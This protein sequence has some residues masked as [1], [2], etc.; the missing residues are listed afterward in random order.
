MISDHTKS[1]GQ[2][3]KVTTTPPPFPT[4]TE[5]STRTIY[6]WVFHILDETLYHRILLEPQISS[7]FSKWNTNFLET[8]RKTRWEMKDHPSRCKYVIL[9]KNTEQKKR[10]NV[11]KS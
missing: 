1:A 2:V 3:G 8:Q 9:N 11:Q 4:H 10:E 5:G 6:S 7:D